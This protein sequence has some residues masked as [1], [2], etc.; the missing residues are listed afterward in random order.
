MSEKMSID[1]IL[2]RAQAVREKSNE[3]IRKTNPSA[4]SEANSRQPDPADVK[5]QP[6]ERD[7]QVNI[8]K[9]KQ[10]AVTAQPADT[11]RVRATHPSK[12]V[13]LPSKAPETFPDA[14]PSAGAPL[15]TPAPNGTASDR[16]RR[17]D[18]AQIAQKTQQV[19]LPSE[20]AKPADDKTRLLKH[21][22]QT[23]AK[24]V[25]SGSNGASD[26][27]QIVR[28]SDKTRVLPADDKTRSMPPQNGRRSFFVSENASERH[29]NDTPPDDIIERP[30]N[31]KSK[32]RFNKTLDLNEIPMI[33]AVDELE[34]TRVMGY[35]PQQETEKKSSPEDDG[36]IVLE[37]FEDAGESSEKINEEEAEQKLLERRRKK[38]DEFRIDSPNDVLE[39]TPQT[40]FSNSGEYNT[41]AGKKEF[42]ARLKSR[43]RRLGLQ[44]TLTLVLTVLLI[45][46]S[47]L[48][49][50]GYLPATLLDP[51]VYRA[52]QA[53]LYLAC[54]VVN[55]F[56]I[57]RGF[58]SVF[59]KKGI[60]SALPISV[61]ALL[62]LVHTALVL[63]YP[64]F[65]LDSIQIFAGA[66]AFSLFVYA[67]GQ[68]MQVLRIIRNFDYI[69]AQDEKYVVENIAN[70]VDATVISRGL[71]Y[72]EPILKTSVRV[73]NLVAF[74]ETSLADDPADKIAR[75]FYPVILFL[76]LVLFVVV[77]VFTRQWPYGF[78]TLTA[79]LLAACPCFACGL[80]ENA[81]FTVTERVSQKGAMVCG[82]AGAE[83][84]EDANAMILEASDLFARKDC[85]LYGMR[86]FNGAKTDEII[87]Q[88][89]AVL[90]RSKTP[91]AAVFD[92][93]IVGKASILP[94]AKDILY[95]DR[96]GLSAWIYGK[97]VLVGNRT[98][99]LHHGVAVPN[100][101]FEARYTTKGRQALY[102]AVAGKLWAMYIFS[103]SADPELQKDL[104]KLEKTGITILAKSTDPYINDDFIADT[105]EV[106]QGYVRVMNAASARVY[107]KYA[108]LVSEDAPA[109]VVH[110]GTVR[111]FINA[112]YAADKLYVCKNILTFFIDFGCGLAFAL[113]ALLSMTN[114]FEQ[115]SALTVAAFQALW[116]FVTYIV[117]KM[118]SNGA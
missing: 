81:L 62:V 68:H 86:Q 41:K 97:K 23:P 48:E 89:A 117:S 38:V 85:N 111:G 32:S 49:A 115:L 84:V 6:N 118:R 91:L 44:L 37:G 106:P 22:A 20:T 113:T 95:E 55:I 110:N 35:T 30:A 79:A 69:S 16:T 19:S 9:T 43:R 102:L 42:L 107:D 72:G 61:G 98:M 87:L 80:F 101:E 50:T 40:G 21:V 59:T 15:Q 116:A 66:G 17:L 99:L 47:V 34:H 2:K 114:G 58:F 70:P 88:T 104:K 13:R 12:P 93:V 54:F 10:D 3:T 53:G 75:T 64:D 7:P 28:A 82:Y 36:Q 65:A 29:F 52:L 18:S 57:F 67:A 8:H 27:T 103:Y 100:S 5:P 60:T 45:V 112:M 11:R 71:L 46:L 92:D 1:E 90:M 51:M 56:T 96:M 63:F 26:K 33:V 77:C 24:S 108:S 25:H 73:K 78:T 109:L 74:D 94:E 83:F 4:F 105:F 39:T 76:S 31:I 14:V